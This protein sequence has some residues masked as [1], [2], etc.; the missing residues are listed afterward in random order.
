MQ[1][2]SIISIMFR[3]CAQ[4]CVIHKTIIYGLK[5]VQQFCIRPV[6][7]GRH[8]NPPIFWVTNGYD[9]P[10]SLENHSNYMCAPNIWQNATSLCNTCAV[11]S[12]GFWDTEANVLCSQS[13]NEFSFSSHMVSRGVLILNIHHIIL[14]RKS[15][16]VRLSWCLIYF[17]QHFGKSW[18][19]VRKKNL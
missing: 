11:K 18:W 2:K 1:I 12:V 16:S 4:K 5:F 19:Q 10:I 17:C 13:Q 15:L 7:T 8:M 14:K 3:K 9:P 6:G